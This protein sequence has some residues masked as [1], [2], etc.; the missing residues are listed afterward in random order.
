MKKAWIAMLLAGC[1]CC[2]SAAEKLL[3]LA[4]DG[5]SEFLKLD[6]HQLGFSQEFGYDCKLTAIPEPGVEPVLRIGTAEQQKNCETVLFAVRGSLFFA[7]AEN[8]VR[9]LTLEE[10]KQILA[11]K[12]RKWNRTDVRVKQICYCGGDSRELPA[13]EKDDP[14]R[15]FVP[16]PMLALH[17]T[18]EELTSVTVIPLI[19]GDS[20]RKG[21]KLLEVGGVLPTPENVMNGLY[22]AATRYFL[23]IRKDAPPEIRAIFEKLRTKQIKETLW[24]AGILPAVEMKK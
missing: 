19:S 2:A 16:E 23:S 22:P 15:I 9:S 1:L 20:R 14:L 18:A 8:P 21:T 17:L 10:T 7:N 3:I 11:G 13:K 5:F 6:V 4:E 24:N 12:F